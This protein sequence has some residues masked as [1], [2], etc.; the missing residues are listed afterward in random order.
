MSKH[1]SVIGAQ[2][3]ETLPVVTRH[4]PEQRA[5][6]MHDLV[7]RER[8]DEIFE[9][10]VMQAEQDLAVVMLA[11]DRILADVLERVVHPAHVPLVTEA[12][13][14]PVHRPRY[15]RTGGRFLG[16]GRCRG[17]VRTGF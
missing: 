3:S 7:M 2:I 15:P 17:T 5:L 13:T 12:Q 14:A 16:G 1:E 10:G 11:V 4:A 8:Q 9:E 6:P